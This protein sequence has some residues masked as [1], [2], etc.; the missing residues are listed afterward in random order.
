MT[1]VLLPILPFDV[2]VCVLSV[3]PPEE[4]KHQTTDVGSRQS[5]EAAAPL[6]TYSVATEAKIL[7][8]LWMAGAA[9]VCTSDV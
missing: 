1:L 8:L 4:K 9:D 5:S 2:P 7:R 3:M 6:E